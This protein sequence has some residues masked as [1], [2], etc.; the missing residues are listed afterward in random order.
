MIFIYVFIDIL[1]TGGDP[2]TIIG[3]NFGSTIKG[4]TVTIGGSSCVVQSV[5]STQII[6]NLPAKTNTDHGVVVTADGQSS[7]D[8]VSFLYDAPIISSITPTVSSLDSNTG[9]STNGTT[10][11]TISGSNFASSSVPKIIR[12]VSDNAI[13]SSVKTLIDHT[14]LSC[15]IPAGP[16]GSFMLY[17]TVDTRTSAGFYYQYRGP[18]L[19]RAILPQGRTTL[20]T[21]GSQIV[22]L[23]GSDF[24]T[25]DSVI[26]VNMGSQCADSTGIQL[27][28]CSCTISSHNQTVI[29]CRSPNGQG[30]VALT[31]CSVLPIFMQISY[32]YKTITN[33]NIPLFTT[34]Y[35]GSDRRH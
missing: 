16:G 8:S 1:H 30:A 5:G 22:T 21:S 29:I 33:Y 15:N 10:I 25:S 13:C 6:C 11:V 20:S 24:G 12:R 14:T 31:I 2:I 7:T 9:S 27:S 17:V 26:S 32:Q 28:S 35:P 18:V 4:L 3:F 23:I 19:T 34:K